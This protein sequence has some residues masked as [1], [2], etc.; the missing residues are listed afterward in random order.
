MFE[1]LDQRIFDASP[2]PGIGVLGGVFAADAAGRSLVRCHWLLSRSDTADMA[3]LRRSDD[4]GAT[5]SEPAPWPTRF[6]DPQ[7]AGR[8]HYRGGYFDPA[9]GRYLTLWTQGVLPT[10][11]PLEGMKRWTLHYAVSHDAGR[12]NAVSEQII[13]EGG[14]YDAIRHMPDITVG[15]NALMS[16]D[17]G[18]RPITRGDGVILLPA[19]CSLTGP[20]GQ[21]H[22]PG[23]GY[24]YTAA[25]VLMGRWQRDGRLAW[26]CSQRIAGDPARS[27]RGMIEPTIATL[28]GDRLLLV[29]R[30]SNDRRPESPGYRWQAISHDGGQSWTAPEPWTYDDGEPFFSPSSCSQLLP[31]SSGRLLWLGNISPTQPVGNGPRYPLMIGEVDRQSGAVRRGSLHAIDDRRPGESPRLSLSNFQAREE[32]ATG[33]VLVYVPRFYA[34]QVEGQPTDY[35][36]HLW[37]YRVA[38][39]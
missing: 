33:D 30:G 11:H 1:L 19:Q 6:D 20:D 37:C 3:W 25:L 21:Y 8:R 24:T 15:S 29:M 27:T 9:T 26:T 16:G 36:A 31:H 17:L 12:S 5:W 32:P 35:T 34:S 10:D 38:V 22:N 13:H 23:G 2:A 39:R 4:G 28:Q 18:E 7:G 14:E